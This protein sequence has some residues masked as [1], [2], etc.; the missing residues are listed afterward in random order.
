M[1]PTICRHKLGDDNKNS[2]LERVST[3]VLTYLIL[4][5]HVNIIPIP[6]VCAESL[7]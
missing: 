5:L 6:E 4:L 7:A 2:V 1:V 3:Y